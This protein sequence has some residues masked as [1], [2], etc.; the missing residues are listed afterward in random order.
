MNTDAWSTRAASLVSLTSWRVES[1]PHH[2][3]ASDREQ[4]RACQ[5]QPGA[6]APTDSTDRRL[7][8]QCCLLLSCLATFTPTTS[9]PSN[10]TGVAFGAR[11]A[12]SVRAFEIHAFGP[13]EPP[14]QERPWQTTPTDVYDSTPFHP[15]KHKQFN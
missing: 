13:L 11:R 14:A 15:S 2:D 10:S 7:S 6:T 9:P 3:P 12:F 4:G 8:A 1:A 5:A